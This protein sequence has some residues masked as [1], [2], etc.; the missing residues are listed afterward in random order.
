M[1]CGSCFD[2]DPLLKPLRVSKDY[3]AVRG[4]IDRLNAAYRA[5]LKG[6]L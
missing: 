6:V 2:Q 1:P 5:A 3:A 4:E